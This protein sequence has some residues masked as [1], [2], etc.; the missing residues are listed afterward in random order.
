MRLV[1]ESEFFAA[2]GPRDVHPRVDVS[3]LKDSKNVVSVWEDQRTRAVVGRTVGS[4]PH[5]RFF[6]AAPAP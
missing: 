4:H 5:T 2:V 3:T 6:L 1:T